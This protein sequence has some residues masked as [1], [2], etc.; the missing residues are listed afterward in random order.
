MTESPDQYSTAMS[1]NPPMSP[2]PQLPGSTTNV[3][4]HLEQPTSNPDPLQFLQWSNDEVSKWLIS[5]HFTLDVVS[6][7]KEH[8]ITGETI[9]YLND[10]H[11]EEMQIVLK[12]KIRLKLEINKLLK[13]ASYPD[14]NSNYTAELETF[15]DKLNQKVTEVIQFRYDEIIEELRGRTGGSQTSTETIKPYLKQHQIPT[16]DTTNSAPIRQVITAPSRSKDSTPVSANGNS[17]LKTPHDLNRP[18]KPST[19]TSATSSSSNNRDSQLFTP[20]PSTAT[21]ATSS[22]SNN[23]DSQLFTPTSASSSPVTPSTLS[24]TASTTSLAASTAPSTAS[25]ATITTASKK[26]LTEPLKQLRASTDDPCSKILQAAMKRHNLTN[27][28][29]R[30]YALV[31]CYGD[32]ERIL[33]LDEKPVLVFK[34]LRAKG[35]HPA[36][37]LRQRAESLGDSTGNGNTGSTTSAPGGKL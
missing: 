13:M 36:I 33:G 31:I 26:P 8:A 3:S 12:D 35:E 21:S 27:A 30:N 37:M 23:R 20:T 7:F 14:Q 19:A 28:D 11:F 4:E 1:I 22:S 10:S 32:K 15:V 17:T 5:L 18:K 29:W 24:H 34:E 6:L 9:P 2:I 16:I 25:S